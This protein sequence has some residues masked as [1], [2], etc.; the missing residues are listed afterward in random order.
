MYARRLIEVVPSVLFASFRGYRGTWLSSDLVAGAVL[1]GIAI[2]EQIATA[3][4]AGMPPQAGLYAFMAGSLVFAVFGSNRFV[5]VGAD[6]TIAPIFASVVV[7]TAARGSAEYVAGIMLVSLLTG[8]I[9]VLAGS[10]RAGWIADL[11]SVPVTIGFLAGIAVHIIIGQLPLMLGVPAEGGSLTVQFIDLVRQASHVNGYA[12]GLGVFVLALALAAERVGARVPGALIGLVLA[13]V[14]VAVFNLRARGVGVLGGL[15]PQLPALSMPAISH[16]SAM[17]RLLPVS[18]IVAIVCMV[19][20]ATVL[21]VF[22]SEKGAFGDMSRDFTAVGLGSIAAGFIGAFAV[23]ASPPRTA[24]ARASGGRSQLAGVIAVVL[25]AVL[26]LFASRLAAYLPQAAFGGVL[27]YIGMRLFR[28]RDM[29]RIARRG[30]FEILLVVAGAFL[31]IAFSIQTGMILSIVL[32][33]VQ[34][35]YI[36]ARPPSSQLV[37]VPNTT[38]WWPSSRDE[39][40]ASVPGVIVF[41]PAA[42]ITFTNAQY[43]VDKLKDLV[44]GA[45]QTVKLVVIE[46]S[47][48]LDVD[49]TGALI[50]STAIAGFQRA[51]VDVAIARL[52]DER[53]QRSAVRTGFVAAVGADHVFQSVQEAISALRP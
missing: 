52:A 39:P 11:L 51:H 23:N 38:I 48:V 28:V 40:G 27:V 30:G 35:L 31:V 41:A 22:G 7:A 17:L 21:R 9:L 20:T 4:L 25:I 53:A 24:V 16:A 19:Q 50:W 2:P 3:H 43:V 12:L 34:G 14:A 1:A 36:V 18:L 44:T 42:P 13:G 45:P 26:A 47:G 8:G 10:A 15:P 37:H 49:Y 6:S 33:L 5:S 32:S 46:C 29:I